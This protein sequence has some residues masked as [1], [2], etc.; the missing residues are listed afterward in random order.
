MIP[1][2]AGCQSF[3]LAKKLE[4]FAFELTDLPNLKGEYQY[5]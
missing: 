3:G 2:G 5:K 1:I 4:V